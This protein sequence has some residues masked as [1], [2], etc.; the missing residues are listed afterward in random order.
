MDRWFLISLA[1][2]FALGACERRGTPNAAGP[3]Q[4][5]PKMEYW[6]TA[7]G[8]QYTGPPQTKY[9]ASP[10]TLDDQ[11]LEQVN[12][13][14]DR[15]FN[16]GTLGMLALPEGYTDYEERR[17]TFDE[18]CN[19]DEPLSN[20]QQT[21]IKRIIDTATR[22]TDDTVVWLY[23]FPMKGNDYIIQPPY[24][25]S[26]SQAVNIH[27]LLFAYCKSGD[28]SYLDLAAK[29][30][31]GMLTSISEGGVL[32]DADGFHWFEELVAPVG[33]NPYIFNGH[34]YS[35]LSLFMLGRETGDEAFTQGALSGVRGLNELLHEVDTGYRTKYDLRPP[36]PVIYIEAHFQPDV[37]V[38]LIRV[39]EPGGSEYTLCAST[40]DAELATARANNSYRFNANLPSLREYHGNNVEVRMAAEADGDVEFFTLSRRPVGS[41]EVFHV[42]DRVLSVDEMGWGQT[43]EAYQVWHALLM[44]EI[45]KWTG[46]D[47]HQETARRWRQYIDDARVATDL[48]EKPAPPQ[49]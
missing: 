44:E 49:H 21:A 36:A 27:A 19:Q 9:W 3:A 33:F 41:A 13:D 10:T 5:G 47:L 6:E 39:W 40:C 29:G 38:E 22:L 30:G 11:T 48:R 46:E 42:P 31:R 43:Q 24:P 26:F 4:G 1:S 32:N 14:G 37:E 35:I 8:E 25:S 7:V 45:H 23:D 20:R 12:A 34:A 28:P 2:L 16:P 15:F 17:T 18:N